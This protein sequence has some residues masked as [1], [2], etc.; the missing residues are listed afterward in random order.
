[1]NSGRGIEPSAAAFSDD[2]DAHDIIPVQ[3]NA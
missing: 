1:M 3:A 2:M